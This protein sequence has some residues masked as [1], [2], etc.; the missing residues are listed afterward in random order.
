SILFIAN[1]ILLVSCRDELPLET[2]EYENYLVV[3]ATLTNVQKQQE[4]KLSRT[5]HLDTSFANIETNAEVYVM[6]NETDRYDFEQTA[7]DG[8][9]FSTEAFSAQT[10]FEYQLFINTEE[11]RS[12]S[13]TIIRPNPPATINNFYAERTVN[14][15]SINGIQVLMDIDGG[16][17]RF[18]RFEY[19][20]TYKV[21]SPFP[22]PFEYE[23]IDFVDDP[24]NGIE[25]DVRL[26]PNPRQE[27][28]CYST[29]NSSGINLGTS[30]SLNE[31]SLKRQ[32]IIFIQE[33]S[34]KIRERYSILGTVYTQGQASY[35]F[36]KNLRDLS[37]NDD[38]LSQKQPGF[39]AGN[40]SSLN[41][42]DEDVLGFFDVSLQS[43]RRIYF[44]YVDFDLLP[45]PYFFSCELDY[46]DYLDN[47]TRDLS[48][49]FRQL[50]YIFLLTGDYKIYSRS[51]P[52]A[53]NSFA[54]IRDYCSDCTLFSSNVKPE[55]WE[56]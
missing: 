7:T 39:I 27:T 56:D 42:Q 49:N 14:A 24:E 26:T 12:Y 53:D 30:G 13:S 38:L 3:E 41:S 6:V 16:E 44:N 50:L 25:Y 46:Y 36:Y 47:T 10:G 35:T 45:P 32:P 29:I 28:V 11:G 31:N 8:S 55:F 23:I 1:F 4:I 5:T 43:E 17:N 22:S 37:T 20:E 51:A 48:P 18:F 19:E 33:D 21:V 9:Y 15:D 34:P 40:I 52:P 54:L 2:F